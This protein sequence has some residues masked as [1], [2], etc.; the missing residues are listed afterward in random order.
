MKKKPKFKIIYNLTTENKGK[1]FK[2][3]YEEAEKEWIDLV[4]KKRWNKL[5][6]KE[7]Q[8]LVMT[9]GSLYLGKNVDLERIFKEFN[10]KKFDLDKFFKDTNK[11][12]KILENKSKR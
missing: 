7:K 4:G 6:E 1:N 9:A 5:S 8:F 11:V 12:G 3:P 2:V 10:W